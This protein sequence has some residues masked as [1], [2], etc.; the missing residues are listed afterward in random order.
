MQ[1]GRKKG[2]K[3]PRMIKMQEDIIGFINKNDK[4][5]TGDIHRTLGYTRSEVSVMLAELKEK[6]LVNF[7]RVGNKHFYSTNKLL[8][9]G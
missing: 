3:S 5:L 7:E 4:C 9:H 8:H 1:K 2:Y 6:N